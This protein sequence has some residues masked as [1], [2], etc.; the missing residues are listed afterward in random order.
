MGRKNVY[1]GTRVPDV[2]EKGLDS[3]EEVEGIVNSIIFDRLS[4]R[5]PP[6]LAAQRMNLLKLVVMRDKDFKGKKR[7]RAIKIVDEG[8]EELKK[9]NSGGRKSSAGKKQQKSGKK[10]AFDVSTFEMLWNL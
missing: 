1:L 10:K 3:L 8:I 4:G 2:G 7:Q 9:I 5:I 6:D